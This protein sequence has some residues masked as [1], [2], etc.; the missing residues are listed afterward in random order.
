MGHRKIKL[1][2]E[3]QHQLSLLMNGEPSSKIFKRYLFVHYLQLGYKKKEIAAMLDVCLNTISNWTKI[4]KNG[5][6]EALSKLDYDG[7][8]ISVLEP[9]KQDIVDF[10]QQNDVYKIAQIQNFIKDDFDINVGCEW[11]GKFIKKNL[12]LFSKKQKLYQANHQ[13]EMCKKSLL[14]I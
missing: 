11:I 2:E 8:R 1:N 14:M 13:A 6:L 4:F 9:I 3:Q 5:G 12:I 7:R 10:V